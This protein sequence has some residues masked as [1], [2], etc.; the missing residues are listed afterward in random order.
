M[1]RE[2]HLTSLYFFSILQMALTVFLLAA[3]MKRSKAKCWPKN[4]TCSS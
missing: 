4:L 2:K 1:R 3:C